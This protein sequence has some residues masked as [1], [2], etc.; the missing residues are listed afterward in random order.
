MV[1]ELTCLQKFLQ[2]SLIRHGRMLQVV[3]K[4]NY[5]GWIVDMFDK[6]YDSF[7]FIIFCSVNWKEIFYDDIKMIEMFWS[8]FWSMFTDNNVYE[9]RV[10]VE[11]KH[12]TM[13][14]IENLDTY[15]IWHYIKCNSLEI[16]V[17]SWYY[18][19]EQNNLKCNERCLSMHQCNV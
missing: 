12:L 18:S 19:G 11:R 16:I 10:F 8:N 17:R 14:K 4:S 15:M 9:M 13:L 5:T 2:H 6:V 7:K 1:Y 3:R